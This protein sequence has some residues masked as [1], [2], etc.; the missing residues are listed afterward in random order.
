MNIWY[1]HHYATPS[2]IAGLH[3]PFEFGKYFIQ[4]GHKVTVFASSYLHYKDDNVI[5]GKERYI[6][7]IY[8]SIDTIFIK[9]KGYK[10]SG[11]KRVLNMYAFYKGLKKA[12]K[13]LLKNGSEKPDVI[14]ASSP[15]PLT[16]MAGN[17]I[18]K[19]LGIPC[20]CEVRDFWPEVFFLSKRLK[21]DSLIGRYL[22]KKEKQIYKN[23]TSLVFL[24]EG[25]HTYITDNKWNKQQ[26][27]PI[28]M[29]KCYYINNGVD[30]SSFQVKAN[31]VNFKD[32][33]LD[34]DKFKVIYCGTI[35]P[36][37]NV[38]ILVDVAKIVGDKVQI[39]IYGTGNCEE[40]IRDRIEKEGVSNLFLKGY[41]E[42]SKVPYVL[43]KSSLNILN[44]SKNDY[45]WSRGNSSNKLFEYFASGKP[46]LSTV[47][48]GYDLLEK[49]GC[50]VSDEIGTPE[51]ISE[52]IL[53]I[54]NLSKEEYQKMCDN[55]KK[56]AED[57]DIKNLAREY[58]GVIEKTI[59]R[60]YRR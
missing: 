35:R 43:S 58:L 54:L 50:G 44:Y 18:A 20:I 27:G 2:S 12:Y 19:K 16:M 24:K 14:I 6:K 48:M 59:D 23:C 28:D 13:K 37:N 31:G 15:H 56:A 55:A 34:S 10:G 53:G 60:H 45:N 33:Q 36:I 52:K 4:S 22:L 25:D 40:K 9:T 29:S 57:F 46:V 8:D 30:L 49:Y 42:N 39:L 1:F 51:S 3:R 5:D 21:K 47:K 26:G 11:I 32:E 38:E 41:I 17:S 7:K